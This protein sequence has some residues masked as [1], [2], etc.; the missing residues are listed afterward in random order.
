M[1]SQGSSG[2]NRFRLFVRF[3]VGYTSSFNTHA[4][5]FY[6]YSLV[7]GDCCIIELCHLFILLTASSRLNT[8]QRHVSSYSGKHESCFWKRCGEFDFIHHS[9]ESIIWNTKVWV[10]GL[11]MLH[12][13]SKMFRTGKNILMNKIL[14]F[15]RTA[16][17]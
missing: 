3:T 10:L 17:R 5:Q 16:W 4:G 9:L 7:K 8:L 13:L 1:Q 15:R 11:F 12:P 14:I 2:I 6:F